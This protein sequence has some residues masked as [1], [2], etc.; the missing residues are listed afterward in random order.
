M[1]SIM[2]ESTSNDARS[3]SG[4]QGKWHRLVSAFVIVAAGAVLIWLAEVV[5]LASRSVPFTEAGITPATYLAG[6]FAVI[7]GLF[8]IHVT[9]LV[10]VGEAIEDRVQPWVPGLVVAALFA[11]SWQETLVQGDGIRSHPYFL[12]IRIIFLV[13]APTALVAFSWAILAGR[14]IDR[15]LGRYLVIAIVGAA[16]V[17]NFY[18]LPTYR[19]FHGHLA[20]FNGVLLV[21]L[22]YPYRQARLLKWGGAAMAVALGISTA[23]VASTGDET[24]R[25]LQRYSSAPSAMM[26]TLPAAGLIEV[27]PER[28]ID[29]DRRWSQ[30]EHRKYREEFETRLQGYDQVRRGNNIVLVVL[31]T[32]RWDHWDDPELTPRFHGWKSR[33]L[34]LPNSVSQY[35]ATPLAYGALFTS[36]P[37]SVLA[38]SSYWGADRPFD[39]I[40][41]EF[42]HKILS[43]PDIS[44]FEHTAITDFFISRDM[45]VNQ[46]RSTER[47][48]RFTRAELETVGEKETFFAWIHLYEPHAP[49]EFRADFE[50]GGDYDDHIAYRSEI[51]YVDHHLGLFVEWFFEQPF[52]DETLLI[53][54]ADHGEGFDDLVFGEKF[55]GHHVHVHNVVSRVPIFLAGPGFGE[56]KEKRDLAAS[57]LDILPTIFD[58]LGREIPLRF[59]PQGDSVYSLVEEPRKRA[60]PTEAFNIRGSRFFDFVESVGESDDPGELRREF[61]RISEEASEYSP[62]L[63]IEYGDYKLIYDRVTRQY[64]LFDIRSDPYEL[65]DLAAEDPKTLAR[66]RDEMDQWILRQSWIVHQLESQ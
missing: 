18:I 61:R 43:K 26:T 11:L 16:M 63:A 31:E 64:S 37:P 29:F 62:K 47:A 24:L 60:L 8:V 33:G 35:P 58:F 32:V 27:S 45:E 23:V 17:V 4:P 51:A 42:D 44:W 12:W 49:Y 53:V 34:Y 30:G 56:G 15:S 10:W 55:R 39:E 2:T 57:Q 52:A 66:L 9:P 54:V 7:V 21:W 20:V 13:G 19:D 22:F 40:A 59:Y 36:Q 48:L 38:S 3:E 65:N 5:Y 28:I 14:L 46:H 41:G 1:I 25:Q 50:R 6:A